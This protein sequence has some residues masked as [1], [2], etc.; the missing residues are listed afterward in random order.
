MER[1]ARMRPALALASLLLLP[2]ALPGLWDCPA[3]GACTGFAPADGPQPS[4][5]LCPRLGP[6]PVW[7]RGTPPSGAPVRPGSAVQVS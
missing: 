1:R 7:L 4:W 6:Q 2:G 3:P 5:W